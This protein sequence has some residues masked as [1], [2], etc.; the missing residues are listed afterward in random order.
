MTAVRLVAAERPRI[1]RRA[2]VTGAAG[3]IGSHLCL[4]LLQQGATVIGVDRRDPDTDSVAAANL[5]GALAN[6]AFVPVTADLRTCAIEPLIIDADAVFHLAA[7]PGVRSSWGSDFD[8][9]VSCNVMATQRLMRSMTRLR[10]PRLVIASSSSVYGG[11][12][13]RPSKE[14]DALRPLSPYAVTKL[15]AEQLCLAY[16]ALPGCPTTVVA[17]RY[18]TVYGPGQREDMFM[19]RLLTAVAIGRS[20]QIYGNG[21]Q[22]RDFTYVDDAVAATISA[23]ATSAVSN[24]VINVGSGRDVCLTEVIDQA[25][26]LVGQPVNVETRPKAA[27]DVPVTCADLSTARQLLGWAPTTDLATGMAVQLAWVQARRSSAV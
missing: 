27:G 19:Q 11:S 18:F 1:I 9:Y 26:R 13:H 25:R 23:G 12:L 8:D 17:L 5:T 16:A 2:V 24:K 15:A 20:I 14:T 7:I 6:P 22:R 3:F 21:T 4:A 10:V